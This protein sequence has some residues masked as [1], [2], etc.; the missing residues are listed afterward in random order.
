MQAS[1]RLILTPLLCIR[2]S[3]RSS[4]LVVYSRRL[5]RDSHGILAFIRLI[6][7]LHAFSTAADQFESA[8]S[9]FKDFG[10][11]SMVVCAG[12]ILVMYTGAR[13]P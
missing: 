4:V 5:S 7:N 10:R 1:P 12:S 13:D 6:Q 11:A 3:M 2:G 9:P 8:K